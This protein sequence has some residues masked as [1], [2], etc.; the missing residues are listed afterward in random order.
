M[1]KTKRTIRKKWNSSQF[2][3][4]KEKGIMIFFAISTLLFVSVQLYTNALL[5]PLGHKLASLNTEKNL[6]LEENRDLE[7]DIA[8]NSSI[9]IISKYADKKLNLT[10]TD[11]SK[12]IYS[13]PAS[14]QASR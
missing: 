8:K 11:N 5:S 10:K 4:T 12:T 3:M 7:Q 2:K 13:T 1:T 6:L 14:V 9:T